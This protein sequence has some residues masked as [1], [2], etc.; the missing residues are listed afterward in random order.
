VTAKAAEAKSNCEDNGVADSS[1]ARSC[2]ISRCSPSILSITLFNWEYDFFLR[3]FYTDPPLAPPRLPRPAPRYHL[4][5]EIGFA[6]SRYHE[7]LDG[8]SVR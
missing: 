3:D 1:A 6:L 4:H 5:H 7:R 8:Y 2:R